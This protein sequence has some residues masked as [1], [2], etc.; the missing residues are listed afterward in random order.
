MHVSKKIFFG[1]REMAIK[2]FYRLERTLS[3]NPKLRSHNYTFISDYLT[4]GNMSVAVTPGE[5]FITH[6]TVFHLVMR[7]ASYSALPHGFPY[8]LV[9][10]LFDSRS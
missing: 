6:Y 3:A 8:I 5:Y 2:R 7:Y 1:S 4:V 10:S 9:K